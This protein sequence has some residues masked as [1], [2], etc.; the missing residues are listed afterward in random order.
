[1]GS[2][3]RFTVL[4]VL[5][6][7]AVPAT[8]AGGADRHAVERGRYLFDAAGCKGCH[9]DKKNKGAPLAG[10]RQIKTPF[11]SFFSPNITPHPEFGIGRWSGDDFRRALRWG[12]APD[13]SHYFPVFPYTS[14]TWMTDGDIAD[15][16]AYL[17]SLPPVARPNRPHSVPP[18]F[19][20]RF[21]VRWWKWLYFTPGP[22]RP[23]PGR[24]GQ[25]NRGA[26]LV[27]ALGHCAE[28]H[29]PRDILGGHKEGMFLA[30]SD[31]GPEGGAIPNITPDGETG[32]GRWSKADLKAL[33]TMGMLPDGDF[34]GAGM[35]EVVENTTGRLAD[36]D[37]EAIIVYLKTVPA[38]RHRINSGQNKEGKD[39][40]AD[41]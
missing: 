17:F 19:A 11:G 28:C 41:W 6:L 24:D 25:W 15:L 16:K 34:A 2:G 21:T 7:L 18:P 30:G 12:I 5:A 9:T 38:V 23:E 14:F 27:K 20:W 32:I 31:E 8:A 33:F 29:T 37:L 13:G 39:D 26:Y 4:A 35:A 36:G 22:M 40:G 10:G 3:S 1:M